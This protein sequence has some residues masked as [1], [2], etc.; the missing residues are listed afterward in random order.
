MHRPPRWDIEEHEA[1]FVGQ[2][3][4]TSQQSVSN[5]WSD[6]KCRAASLGRNCLPPTSAKPFPTPAEL[7]RRILGLGVRRDISVLART[8]KPA[9]PTNAV[10]IR[11]II[12][13]TSIAEPGRKLARTTQLW[14]ELRRATTA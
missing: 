7:G 9:L 12:R 8:Q 11:Q 5:R 2:E 10:R 6:W 13:L 4:C 14:L 1:D 3:T